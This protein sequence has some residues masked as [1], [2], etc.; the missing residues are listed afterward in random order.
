MPLWAKDFPFPWTGV[1]KPNL[2]Q[3]GWTAAATRYLSR[4]RISGT[5]AW[6]P[7]R[8]GHAR[9]GIS[10]VCT[11]ALVLWR[12]YGCNYCIM[13]QS[14]FISLLCQ[15]AELYAMQQQALSL[16][17]TATSHSNGH[18]RAKPS[19]V[20]YHK[21]LPRMRRRELKMTRLGDFH[22]SQNGHL[23]CNILAKWTCYCQILLQGSL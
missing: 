15:Y 22:S 14:I 6:C 10:S 7:P 23:R 21:S 19:H 1:F 12:Q 9:S 4:P 2:W 13:M 20:L 3:T 18:V 8:E 16:R 5:G 11:F 17:A